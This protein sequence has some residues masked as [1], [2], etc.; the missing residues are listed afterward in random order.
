MVGLQFIV[1]TSLPPL[2][3]CNLPKPSGCGLRTAEFWFC[4]R[5]QL[6]CCRLSTAY[7]LHTPPRQVGIC[8]Q[9]RRRIS[10]QLVDSE[11]AQLINCG[12]STAFGLHSPPRPLTKLCC[13][14]STHRA[15]FP[16]ASALKLSYC[17]A[18]NLPR[19]RYRAAHDSFAMKRGF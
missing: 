17:R 18:T 16:L 8:G 2:T 9:P 10:P 5:R 3:L 14:S 15:E 11:R 19:V 1:G 13:Q 7:E 4:G 6:V 12:N